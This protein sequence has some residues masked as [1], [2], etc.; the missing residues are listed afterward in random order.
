MLLRPLLPVL[1]ALLPARG[2]G[3]DP[4]RPAPFA[5]VVQELGGARINWTELRL[6]ATTH[7]EMT[8]G[9][10]KDRRVQE[11]DAL[12]RVGPLIEELARR[13]AVTRG[14]ALYAVLR[15]DDP[16]AARLEDGMRNWE[17]TETRYLGQGGV[18]MTASLPISRWLQPLLEQVTGPVSEQLPADGTTGLVIDARGLPFDPALVPELRTPEPEPKVLVSLNMFGKDDGQHATPVVYVSDPADPRAVKRAGA[19]PVFARATGAAPGVLTV[20][21]ELPTSAADLA[22]L[23]AARRVVVVADP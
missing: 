11:Q 18:E 20:T 23:I 7:S 6:E 2:D 14:D 9:A 8:V 21:A 4:L 10:W 12:E 5:P 1:L 3:A 22:L 19:K 17:V 15:A 13:L 16:L